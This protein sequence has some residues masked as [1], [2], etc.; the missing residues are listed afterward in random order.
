[1][2]LLNSVGCLF[3]LCVPKI[4]SV[5]LQLQIKFSV[6]LIFLKTSSFLKCYVYDILSISFR[7]T[8]ANSSLLFIYDK[9]SSIDY[10][11]GENIKYLFRILF[12]IIFFCLNTLLSFWKIYF[13]IPMHFWVSTSHFPLSVT[14][15]H[16]CISASAW[17][18]HPI[19]YLILWVV[20]FA[21]DHV[22]GLLTLK[23]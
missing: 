9:L 4:S 10:H 20:S 1:M 19:I 18:W 12:L 13:T 15:L 6:I 22:F 5:P 17:F 7:S 14:T 23:S 3:L 16:N 2:W 11:I 8:F 21:N